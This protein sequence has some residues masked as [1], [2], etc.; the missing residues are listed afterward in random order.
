M[1]SRAFSEFKMFFCLLN[2]YFSHI[3]TCYNSLCYCV[4]TYQHLFKGMFLISDGCNEI[5]FCLL[6]QWPN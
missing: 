5:I 3:L 6:Y 4:Y 1:N 2:S